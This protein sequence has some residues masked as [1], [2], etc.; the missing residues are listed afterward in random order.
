MIGNC[1]YLM[2][3]TTKKTSILLV[4]KISFTSKKF[5]TFEQNYQPD[6]W[7]S[8]GFSQEVCYNRLSSLKSIFCFLN[9]KNVYKFEKKILIQLRF[10]TKSPVEWTERKFAL[11]LKCD[12]MKRR[13]KSGD[14]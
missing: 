9:Q 14:Y 7:F 5:I 6:L 3:G 13:K 8:V 10:A 4:L 12:P 2:T 11:K 1:V